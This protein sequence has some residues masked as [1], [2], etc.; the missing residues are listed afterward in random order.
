MAVIG[1]HI[2]TDAAGNATVTQDVFEIE[3]GD[4]IFFT[5]EGRVDAGL[6]AAIKYGNSSPFT[7]NSDPTPNKVVEVQARNTPRAARKKFVVD[8]KNAI[9]GIAI[10]PT[11]CPGTTFGVRKTFPFACGQAAGNNLQT[12]FV[13]W[14]GGGGATPGG[15]DDGL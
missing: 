9:D 6:V 12:T 11:G 14:A 4:K 2:F 10:I 15:G 5:H 7:T 1:Y 8:K 13:P 3:P